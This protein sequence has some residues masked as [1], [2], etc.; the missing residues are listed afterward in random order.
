MEITRDSD[1]NVAMGIYHIQ[2][3][4]TKSVIW[5]RGVRL[6]WILNMQHLETLKTFTI[7]VCL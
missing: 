5:A 7:C 4:I 6:R 2:Q 1:T 3:D